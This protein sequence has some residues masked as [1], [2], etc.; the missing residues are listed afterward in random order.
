MN[1]IVLFNSRCRRTNCSCISRRI[2]GSSALNGSSI[3]RISGVGAQRPCQPDTLLHAAGELART[4][5]FVTGKPDYF[6]PVPSACEALLLRNALDAQ[7]IGDIVQYVAVRE[8]A[9]AL[10]HHA[11]LIAP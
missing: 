5:L 8:Q 9:E 4:H 6:D 10:E 3:S 11:H 1:T 2:N 7:A